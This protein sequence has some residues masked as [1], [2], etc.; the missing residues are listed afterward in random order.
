MEK[1]NY[2][3]LILNTGLAALGGLV[4]RLAEMEDKKDDPRRSSVMYY[5]MGSV[6][7]MFVG[8]VVYFLC[9]HFGISQYLTAGLTSLGGYMGAPLLDLLS[10]LAVKKVKKA[11]DVEA[12]QKDKTNK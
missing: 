9:K 4:R 6:I 12:E 3:E 7:S 2:I 1:M 5:L 10:H 11:A 8:V